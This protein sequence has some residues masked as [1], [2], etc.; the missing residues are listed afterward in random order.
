MCAFS[1]LVQ[2]PFR[3]P[4]RTQRDAGMRMEIFPEEYFPSGKFFLNRTY[5]ENYVQTYYED[6]LIVHSNYIKGHDR[7]RS[8]FI[9][10]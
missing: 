6:I 7:K 5:E 8:R 2:I 1:P 9:D 4:L 3:G 10:Y